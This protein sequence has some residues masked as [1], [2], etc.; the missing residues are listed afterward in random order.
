MGYHALAM[1]ACGVAIAWTYAWQSSLFLVCVSDSQCRFNCA[2]LLWQYLQACTCC[3]TV[4]HS[5]KLRT[6][7]HAPCAS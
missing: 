6:F 3:G 1:H 7:I 5:C 2:Q 4:P